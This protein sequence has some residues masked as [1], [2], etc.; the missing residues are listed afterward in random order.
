MEF[1]SFQKII[2]NKLIFGRILNTKTEKN[3]ADTYL[4]IKSGFRRELLSFSLRSH[5]RY[6]LI[7]G[8]KK[9]Y[10]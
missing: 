2:L 5:K 3:I 9:P 10:E 7:N 8:M 4:R 6:K 1:I